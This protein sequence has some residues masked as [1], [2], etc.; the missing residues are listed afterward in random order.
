MMSRV[1]PVCGSL[2]IWALAAALA[3]QVIEA[4]QSAQPNPLRSVT[5][6]ENLVK[7]AETQTAVLTDTPD[8]SEALAR[9]LFAPDRRQSATEN[10]VES[11]QEIQPIA[12]NTP[13]DTLPAVIVYGVALTG[14]HAKAL[15]SINESVPD[16]YR[17]KDIIAGWTLTKIENNGVLLQSDTSELRIELY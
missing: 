10:T 17:E 3:W 14:Q 2:S 7:L 4:R 8:L 6:L 5:A 15:L 16:W 12:E 11:P 9:P 1:L 13:S